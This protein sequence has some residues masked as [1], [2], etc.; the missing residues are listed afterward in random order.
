MT[1]TL[2]RTSPKG[3]DQR[4]I[5]RCTKCGAE[6]LR[7]THALVPCPADDVVSD[8]AALIEIIKGG[9]DD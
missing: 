6:G 7:L 1:H 2:E 9:S 3:P 4:F 8:E 5:G